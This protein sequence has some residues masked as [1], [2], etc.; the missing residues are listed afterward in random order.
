MF[1]CGR[2]ALLAIRRLIRRTVIRRRWLNVERRR[3]DRIPSACWCCRC[4]MNTIDDVTMKKRGPLMANVCVDI[5]SS[6]RGRCCDAHRCDIVR[7]ILRHD[8]GGSDGGTAGTGWRCARRRFACMD[9]S[10]STRHKEHGIAPGVVCTLG[11]DPVFHVALTR[12]IRRSSRNWDRCNSWR[13]ERS[14]TE[15]TI[16]E[17]LYPPYA[18]VA[19]SAAHADRDHASAAVPVVPA[20]RPRLRPR[21]LLLR[22]L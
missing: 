12:K 2:R 14:A 19:I 16:L 1:G 10:S 22:P 7:K 3:R 11:C 18:A 4:V 20:P 5:N 15:R 9:N 8:P 17:P 6:H 13:S 21:P